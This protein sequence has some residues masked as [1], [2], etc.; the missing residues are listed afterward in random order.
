MFK[1]GVYNK[2]QKKNDEIINKIK[3]EKKKER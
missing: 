2:Q 3:K 1:F